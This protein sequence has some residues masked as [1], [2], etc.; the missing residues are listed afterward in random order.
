MLQHLKQQE[1]QTLSNQRKEKTSGYPNFPLAS[2]L[3]TASPLEVVPVPVEPRTKDLLMRRHTASCLDPINLRENVP[4]SESR[5]SI[6]GRLNYCLK[7]E[8]IEHVQIILMSEGRMNSCSHRVLNHPS[9]MIRWGLRPPQI[10]WTRSKRRIRSGGVAKE[11]LE[12]IPCTL[13]RLKE[14]ES[15]IQ[16]PSALHALWSRSKTM[17]EVAKPV[18]L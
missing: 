10:R 2:C 7:R 15:E 11:P 5:I 1:M 9:W 18:C 17:N 3:C 6:S 8:D 16:A 4:K 14:D 12:H 13:S